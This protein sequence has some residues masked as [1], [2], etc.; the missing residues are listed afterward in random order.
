MDKKI[1]LTI[2]RRFAYMHGGEGVIVDK[3]RDKNG[4]WVYVVAGMKSEDRTNMIEALEIYGYQFSFRQ[5][6]GELM[7]EAV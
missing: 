3:F 4:K 1:N 2:V 5:F 6:D 7:L